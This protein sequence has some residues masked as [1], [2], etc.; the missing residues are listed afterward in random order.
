V[1]DQLKASSKELLKKLVRA[2]TGGWRTFGM[3]PVFYAPVFHSP[4]IIDCP[5]IVVL[6]RG[7]ELF[8]ENGCSWI[9]D[10][11]KI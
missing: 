1:D 11:L 5:S 7:D 10:A 3:E 9:E 6:S 8:L 2:V 4:N